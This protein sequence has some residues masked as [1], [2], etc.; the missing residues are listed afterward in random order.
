MS[1]RAARVRFYVDADIRGFG[2]VIGSVR[3]D[4]TYPVDP[5]AV[6]NKR[7]PGRRARSPAPNCWTP[8]GYLIRMIEEGQD[9]ADVLTQLAPGRAGPWTGPAS[10][11]SPAGSASA[12]STSRRAAGRGCRRRARPGWRRLFLS[13]A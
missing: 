2:Q 3:N 9:C 1:Y 12:C 10:G 8:S 6:T 13:L 5:G 4:V 11:S 7:V